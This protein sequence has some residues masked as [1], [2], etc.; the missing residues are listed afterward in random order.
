MVQIG[1]TSK[2]IGTGVVLAI[3]YTV[4]LYML[5]KKYYFLTFQACF[6]IPI[7][8]SNLNSN[9]SNFVKYEKPPGGS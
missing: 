5:E 9:C 1:L 3:S 2:K 7:F 4:L 6:Y 8:F